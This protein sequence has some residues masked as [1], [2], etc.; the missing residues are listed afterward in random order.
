MKFV[1]F[2]E[3]HTEKKAVP[4]FLK[5][6]LDPQLAQPVGFKVV[7]FEGWANYRDSIAGHARLHLSGKAGKDVNAGIGLLDLYG[8]TIYPGHLVTAADRREWGKQHFE[9]LVGDAR[10]VQHFAVHKA[11]AWLLSDPSLF[12]TAVRDALPGKVAHPETVNFNA[13]PARL[14][15]KLYGEKLKKPYKK[16]TDGTNLFSRLNPATAYARCPF[17]RQLLD[18]LL[19]LAKAAGL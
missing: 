7:R 14:L 8:P 19:G 1:L 10:F 17:L 4:R 11:E 12:P 13:P 2:V 5:A 6:W 18:D 15:E 9:G 3:G 16:V